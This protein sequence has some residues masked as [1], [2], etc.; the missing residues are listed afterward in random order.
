M[1]NSIEYDKV[2]KLFHAQTLSA[3]MWIEQYARYKD[4]SGVRN[5]SLAI[6]KLMGLFNVLLSMN[7]GSSNVGDDIIALVTRYS[8]VWDNLTVEKAN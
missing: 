8:G 4:V 5:A 7:G 2:V 6:G 3:D 1:S